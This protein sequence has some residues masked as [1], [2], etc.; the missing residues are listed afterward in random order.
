MVSPA[1][2]P[3]GS[4]AP[5]QRA[6]SLQRPEARPPLHLGLRDEGLAA[7][8]QRV[9]QRL[10]AE[11]RLEQLVDL[12]ATKRVLDRSHRAEAARSRELEACKETSEMLEL[13]LREQSA[14]LDE[15]LRQ[16]PDS[17]A[18]RGLAE[19]QAVLATPATHGRKGRLK[20]GEVVYK[21][22]FGSKSV[23]KDV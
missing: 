11:R 17:A 21:S 8:A 2:L 5:P 3:A 1:W 12:K 7:I 14:T 15:L 20:A 9:V 16:Q 18:A 10:H 6:S 23:C 22:P 19:R 13:E 4:E